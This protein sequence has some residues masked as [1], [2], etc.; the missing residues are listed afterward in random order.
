MEK[1]NESKKIN[2]KK[3]ESK[4]NKKNKIIFIIY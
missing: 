3:N 1:K 2:Q 4:K